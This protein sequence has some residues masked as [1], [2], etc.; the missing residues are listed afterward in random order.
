MNKIVTIKKTS[1]KYGKVSIIDFLEELF[2]PRGTPRWSVCHASGTIH[3]SDPDDAIQFG[4][5]W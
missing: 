3:F 5:S 1:P 2:G 4:F